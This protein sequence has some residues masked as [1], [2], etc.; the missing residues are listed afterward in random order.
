LILEDDRPER[1]AQNRLERWMFVG[2]LEVGIDA[3]PLAPLDVRVDR[4]ALDRPGPDDR[5]LDRDVLQ[6]LWTRP[7]ERLHLCTA[8]DLEDAGRVRRLNAL[9]GC[10]SVVG[11]PREIDSLATCA[12]DHLDAPLDRR[13]HPETEQVDLQKARV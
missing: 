1:L 12:R 5:D 8:L 2:N 6:V 7:P 9:V 10:R 13:E 4:P 11:N 3:H